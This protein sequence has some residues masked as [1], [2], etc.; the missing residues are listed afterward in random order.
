[1]IIVVEVERER[2]VIVTYAR[3]CDGMVWKGAILSGN[4]ENVCLFTVT[5]SL[6]NFLLNF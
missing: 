5:A 4:A 2:A 6:I 1:M 3:G